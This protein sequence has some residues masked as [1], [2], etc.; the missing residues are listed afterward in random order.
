[1]LK[2]IGF[3]LTLSLLSFGVVLAA[4]HQRRTIFL[5]DLDD[6]VFEPN[7]KRKAFWNFPD[8]KKAFKKAKLR[9]KLMWY[10]VKSPFK[11]IPS[12]K[13]ISLGKRHNSPKF[14]ELTVQVSAAKKP[15][16]ETLNVINEL[17]QNG[18]TH[19]IGSNIGQTA[20]NA[21]TDA[22]L[23]PQFQ[24]VFQNFELDKSQV[25]T[26]NNGKF[27]K[28]PHIEFFEQYLEKN[29]I[30]LQKTRIIFIDNKKRNVIAAWKSGLE[31]ILF[32]NATQLRRDLAQIGITINNN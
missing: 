20:F 26:N 10:A 23:Y 18:Y 12:E 29:K 5:W 15:I 3:F 21:I 22:N 17:T 16:E 14:T 30:N 6:V 25:V 4:T 7:G 28:K 13:I 1:M 27:V 9:S 19:H 11:S 32:K 8:K 24:R 31:G 2:K